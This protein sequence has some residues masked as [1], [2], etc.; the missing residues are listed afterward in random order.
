MT[1]TELLDRIRREI[2]D[3]RAVRKDALEAGFDMPSYKRG[4]LDALDDVA[5][6]ITTKGED[7]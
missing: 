7:R 2:D 5:D 6:A 1:V 3:G 4:Y